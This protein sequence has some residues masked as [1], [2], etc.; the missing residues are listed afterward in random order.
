MGTCVCVC[1]RMHAAV[2]IRQP[3]LWC[4]SVNHVLCWQCK[5][6]NSPVC[7]KTALRV[8]NRHS[9]AFQGF[10]FTR[11]LDKCVPEHTLA[12]TS[13]SSALQHTQSD[14]SHLR[15][16]SVT[17]SLA[18]WTDNGRKLRRRNVW[19]LLSKAS[20]RH[21]KVSITVG[22]SSSCREDRED[23]TNR[24]AAVVDKMCLIQADFLTLCLDSGTSLPQSCILATFLP[25]TRQQA[26]RCWTWPSFQ[27]SRSSS[28][29]AH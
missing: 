26:C 11:G 14:H 15:Q 5:V 25:P 1:V 22:A 8:Q 19:R 21:I 17:W 24:S 4:E 28:V 13:L 7:N 3:F 12:Q 23:F 18:C 27:N 6:Q 16:F 20:T 10:C 9:S 2:C 29:P